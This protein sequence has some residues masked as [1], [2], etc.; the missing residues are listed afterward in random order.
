VRRGHLRG[1][2]RGSGVTTAEIQ[3][4]REWLDSWGDGANWSDPKGETV[5]IAKADLVKLL[6]AASA[7]HPPKGHERE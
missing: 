7:A 2:L 6:D 1:D 4:M 3:S 5:P